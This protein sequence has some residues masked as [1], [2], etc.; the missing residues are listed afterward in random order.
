MN[1]HS[2]PPPTPPH[3]ADSVHTEALLWSTVAQLTQ[4]RS[5]YLLTNPDPDPAAPEAL[6][7]H[8]PALG[9]LSALTALTSLD[10]VLPRCYTPIADSHYRR[11]CSG[12]V[13]AD[14]EVVRQLQHTA[15]LSALQ[16]MPH[17]QHLGCPTLWIPSTDPTAL[18]SLTNLTSLTLGGLLLP[19]PPPPWQ[20][21]PCA[22]HGRTRQDTA[23]T[24]RMAL[25]RTR[26]TVAA[27]C[28]HCCSS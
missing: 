23:A 13:W 25:M 4:L 27:C 19:P 14:W 20:Q 7:P 21:P 26:S 11:W 16:C 6:L 15:I 22:G 28:L 9:S 17:L 18:A 24:P 2:G 8:I 10:L 5:L 12:A 3:P 1:A